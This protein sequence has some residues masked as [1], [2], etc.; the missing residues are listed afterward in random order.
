MARPRFSHSPALVGPARRLGGYTRLQPRAVID[1]AAARRRAG[2]EVRP[3]GDPAITLAYFAAARRALLVLPPKA[4]MSGRQPSDRR[5]VR[6]CGG[7]SAECAGCAGAQCVVWLHQDGEL[8]RLPE[9]H[10]AM[11]ASGADML[12]YSVARVAP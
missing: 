12:A 9:V 2:T 5:S 8:S 7:R 3:R 11:I 4:Q 1:A 10:A 6:A